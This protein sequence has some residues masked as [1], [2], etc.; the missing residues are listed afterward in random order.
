MKRINWYQLSLLLVDQYTM[1]DEIS[2]V[3]EGLGQLALAMFGEGLI[4]TKA[5]PTPAV[6]TLSGASLGG[7]VNQFFSIDPNGQI[8]EN[9]NAAKAFTI[10][11]A[12]ATHSRKDLLVAR[13]KMT[14]DT[15]VPQPSAPLNTVDFYLHDDFDLVVI[16][17][18]PGVSP[19]YPS[20][21]PED[22]IIEGILVPANATLGTGCTLDLSVRELAG[23]QAGQLQLDTTKLFASKQ[24]F[25]QKY[26]EA[27]DAILSAGSSEMR[28][29]GVIHDA[30]IITVNSAGVLGDTITIGT[31][32]YTIGTG[33]GQ[34]PVQST[35][36]ILAAVLARLLREDATVN[37]ILDFVSGGARVAVGAKATGAVGTALAKT[38]TTFSVSAAN[39]SGNA[40][41]TF[42]TG[43]SVKQQ[44]DQADKLLTPIGAMMDWPS[45]SAPAGW[46]PR[47]GRSL[48]RAS[49]PNLFAVIGTTFGAADGTHF[50]LMDDR[51]LF[52]RW[53]N[54]SAGVDP[55]ASSRVAPAGT[56]ATGAAGDHV[57]TT[58]TDQFGSH[59][60]STIHDTGSE[61]GGFGLV[62]GSGNFQ[63][64]VMVTGSGGNP[65]T[66]AAG[67][68]ES[69][70]KNRAYLPII[71]HD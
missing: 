51:G 27:T 71:K 68:N 13:Y 7:T 24:P 37:T 34:I 49:Y 54:N 28:D 52:S 17:G 61:A 18:T 23:F 64:R 44:L 39:I 10:S 59:Q 67:G 58:Q 66:Y 6:V 31:T 5:Y 41:R 21:N 22:V 43:P 48:L 32:T 65:A 60:H 40:A 15:P 42:L 53:W 70:P 55:D 57:G 25:L 20:K 35:A 2:F 29:D 69:R 8:I 56:G 45:E 26:L 11:A 19:V 50:N 9:D 33:V 62:A 47:D 46:F 38:G 36:S 4:N 3:Q 63:D 1:S 30:G 12:D 14:G 16:A